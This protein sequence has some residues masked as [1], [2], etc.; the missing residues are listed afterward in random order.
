M[1]SRLDEQAFRQK[2]SELIGGY[3]KGKDASKLRI[4]V[5]K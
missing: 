3:I 4:I 5:K 2:V 1:S